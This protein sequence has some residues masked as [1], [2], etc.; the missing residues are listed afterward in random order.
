MNRQVTLCN[1]EDELTNSTNIEGASPDEVFDQE[2][3][4]QSSHR[5]ANG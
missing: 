1:Q 2:T 3:A 4:E 5:T